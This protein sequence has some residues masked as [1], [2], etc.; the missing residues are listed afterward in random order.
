MNDTGRVRLASWKEIAAYLRR[1][2]R[3]VI[4]WEKERGLPVH[5]VPGGQ[6]GS[7]FAFADEL[8]RWAAGESSNEAVPVKRVYPRRP[9][10]LVAAA[11][12]VV[13]A[14]AAAATLARAWTHREIAR[15]NAVGTSIEAFDQDGRRLWSYALPGVAFHL[16]RRQA[17]LVEVNG[18][19]RLDALVTATVA[20]SPEEVGTGGLYAL[21]ESGEL[22]WKRSIDTRLTFGAGDFEP[23]WQPDDLL[24]FTNGGEPLA[25]WSVHHHTWWPSMLAVFD[26]RGVRLGAFAQAGWIRVARASVDGRHIITGGFSNSRKGA[27]FAVLDARH[28]DGASPEEPGSSYECRNC[29]AGRPVRYFTVDW[30]DIASSL[31]PDERDALVAV[32]P[33]SGTIELRAVQRRGVDLIIE[34]SPSFEIVKR[35]VSDTFWE[36]HGRLEQTG[37]IDHQR[38]ACPYR[39]GPIVREWTPARGWRTIG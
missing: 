34:L 6:G 10:A 20:A 13:L 15:I 33:G 23:P 22:L 32:Y 8:D 17:Q 16:P 14:G 37:S 3:T 35:S 4:R 25:A 11:I 29:P 19:G 39:D 28:P 18:N 31:P 24:A 30:S 2:V 12:V 26:A 36:W 1:E 7:V 38:N 5:R 21:S 9:A 27:A